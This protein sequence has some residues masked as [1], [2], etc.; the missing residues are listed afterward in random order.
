M[1]N[2]IPFTDEQIEEHFDEQSA[3]GGCFEN[4]TFTRETLDDFR[5]ARRNYNEP[6]HLTEDVLGG[7]P[8]IIMEDVQVAKGHQRKTVVVIDYGSVRA[9]ML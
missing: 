1:R 3:I 7:F 2:E 4:V 5:A 9:A 8:A 6:G